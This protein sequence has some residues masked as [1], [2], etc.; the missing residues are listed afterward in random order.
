MK[1]NKVVRI[2]HS[3]ILFISFFLIYYIGF[4]IIGLKHNIIN[5]IILGIISGCLVQLFTKI[6]KKENK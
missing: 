6:F 2:I 3:L 1:N 4:E 5:Y